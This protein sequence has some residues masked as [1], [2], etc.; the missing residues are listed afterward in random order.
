MDSKE[1]T[2]LFNNVQPVDIKNS[3]RLGTIFTYLKREKD[4]S[5]VEGNGIYVIHTSGSISHIET[6]KSPSTFTIIGD[7][8]YYS[9]YNKSN[10]YSLIYKK[11]TS[12][13]E[14]QIA[15]G[16]IRREERERETMFGYYQDSETE[17]ARF[18]K[19]NTM[20]T[21]YEG[22]CVV[23]ENHKGLIRFLNPDGTSEIITGGNQQ[24][25]N[26]MNP[27]AIV[28][29]PKGRGFIVLDNYNI[30]MMRRGKENTYHIWTLVKLWNGFVPISEA[31]LPPFTISQKFVYFSDGPSYLDRTTSAIYQLDLLK[32]KPTTKPF[33]TN[34]EFENLNIGKMNG[35]HVD[36][37]GKMLVWTKDGIFRLEDKPMPLLKQIPLKSKYLWNPKICTIVKR[38]VGVYDYAWAFLLTIQRLSEREKIPETPPEILEVILARSDVWGVPGFNMYLL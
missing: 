31:F 19:I 12:G 1:T 18:A 8:I 22:R 27:T 33:M 15:G 25:K 4:N 23:C 37:Q 24:G 30:M 9:H 5:L 16:P 14:F 38:G 29:L 35:F 6:D 21:T 28:E 20:I 26:F 2:I 7:E 36:S 3:P 17:V 32:K 34:R 10:R 11:D 13:K